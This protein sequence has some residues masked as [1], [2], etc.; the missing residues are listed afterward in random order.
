MYRGKC[1]GVNVIPLAQVSRRGGYDRRDA[2]KLLQSAIDLDFRCR[3]RLQSHV[4]LPRARAFARDPGS[5]TRA[6]DSPAANACGD[7]WRSC[8]ERIAVTAQTRS[9]TAAPP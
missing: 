2:R 3:L 9:T 4:C 5:T 7:C 6:D 8:F 1:V